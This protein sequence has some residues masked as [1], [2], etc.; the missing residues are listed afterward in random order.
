M[1][2]LLPLSVGVILAASCHTTGVPFPQGAMDCV[3]RAANDQGYLPAYTG[4]RPNTLLL[5]KRSGN[6]ADDLFV[7]ATTDSTGV[8]HVAVTPSSLHFADGT[9][10]TDHPLPTSPDAQRAAAY[11]RE[12]CDGARS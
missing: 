7:T 8:S 12:R 2:P 10:P 6:D 4:E 3:T 5:R 11:V 1:H 9:D